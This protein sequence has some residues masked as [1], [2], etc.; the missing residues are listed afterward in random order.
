ML[1]TSLTAT[2]IS[3]TKL[4]LHTIKRFF[5]Y[6][7]NFNRFIT[8]YCIVNHRL[9]TLAF[10]VP[11][12]NDIITYFCHSFVSSRSCASPVGFPISRIFFNLKPVFFCISFAD[13]ISATCTPRNNNYIVLFSDGRQ[14]KIYIGFCLVIFIIISAPCFVF[15]SRGCFPGCGIQRTCRTKTPVRSW[16]SWSRPARCTR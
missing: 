1:S 3:T 6:F 2:V 16:R 14:A 4:L 15:T 11:K 13:S 8:F 10:L 9:C 12:T 5:S 7:F